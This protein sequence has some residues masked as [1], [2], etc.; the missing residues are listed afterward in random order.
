V[1]TP[2]NYSARSRSVLRQPE[3]ANFDKALW[4]CHDYPK[5]QK[6]EIER[7]CGEV[8]TFERIDVANKSQT[9]TLDKFEQ[10]LLILHNF[11]RPS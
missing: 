8:L 11:L 10:S 3:S 1:R 2:S 9:Q 7:E 5:K 4:P 6:T